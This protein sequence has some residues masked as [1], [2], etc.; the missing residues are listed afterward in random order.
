MSSSTSTPSMTPTFSPTSTMYIFDGESLYTPKPIVINVKNNTTNDVN[1]IIISFI[2][3]ILAC[4]IIN[5]IWIQVDKRKRYQRRNRIAEQNQYVLNQIVV[6][7]N[8]LH[9]TRVYV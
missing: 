3:L 2:S 6:Q 5:V 8:P 7:E 1:I 4:F 9:N